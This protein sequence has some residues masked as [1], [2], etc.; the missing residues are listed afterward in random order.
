MPFIEKNHLRLHYEYTPATN[1]TE[2]TETIVLIHGLAFDLRSWDLMIPFMNDYHILAY[3][4]RGHGSTDRGNEAASEAIYVED[5]YFLLNRLNI[6]KVHLVAHGAGTLIALYFSRNYFSLVQ[7]TILLSIPVFHSQETAMK[8][9]AYRKDYQTIDAI[10]QHVIPNVTRYKMG[11]LEIEKLFASYSKVSITVYFE[12]MDFFMNHHDDILEMFKRHTSPTLILTGE[13]DSFYPTYLSS[14]IA[15]L[16]PICRYL[17]MP[18]SSNL[19]AYDQPEA[20]FLQI[21]H[22][23]KH[24]NSNHIQQAAAPPSYLTALKADFAGLLNLNPSS[25]YRALTV[26]LIETFEVYIDGQPVTSGWGKR[27]A[28]EIL[29]YLLFHPKISRDQLCE[30][31]WGHMEIR[32]ARN[33]LRVCL[34]HLKQ[35]LQHDEKPILNTTNNFISLSDHVE[36]QSDLLALLAKINSASLEPD[37]TARRQI[38]HELFLQIDHHVFRNLLGDWSLHIRV[39]AE[40]QLVQLFHEQVAFLLNQNKH[41]EAN[42]YLNIIA[43][44]AP[45]DEPI[46]EV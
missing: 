28:K 29:I 41:S 1:A 16:N 5:L 9:A 6:K 12:L 39:K 26:N 36:V 30:D 25:G 7:S 27:S 23:L 13:Y 4:F 8:F 42:A 31:L 2:T 11:S 38:V 21:E 35:V 17:T 22:F 20:T 24:I 44:F 14:L 43:I 18:N 46:S 34:S 10:A 33:Q 37:H 45:E 32:K 3:D 40:I 19:I 15:S